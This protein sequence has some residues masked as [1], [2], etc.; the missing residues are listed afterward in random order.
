MTTIHIENLYVNTEPDC[1][2]PVAGGSPQVETYL[3]VTRPLKYPRPYDHKPG[4]LDNTQSAR[5]AVKCLELHDQGY[6]PGINDPPKHDITDGRELPYVIAQMANPVPQAIHD[7]YSASFREVPLQWVEGAL[8]RSWLSG[9]K[10]YAYHPGGEPGKPTLVVAKRSVFQAFLPWIPMRK[11]RYCHPTPGQPRSIN[12]ECTDFAEEAQAWCVQFGHSACARTL[13]LFAHHSW[14]WGACYED[15]ADPDD[16][17]ADD[18]VIVPFEPQAGVVIPGRN[19]ANHYDG[20][21]GESQTT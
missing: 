10:M 6:R 1:D 9:L 18:I 13:D 19:P 3:A 8:D 2:I 7:A 20:R 15:G 11:K 14:C 17:K 4:V 16:L 5:K 21:R 12:Y